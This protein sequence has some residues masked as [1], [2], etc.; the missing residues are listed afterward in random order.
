MT[1]GVSSSTE[2]RPPSPAGPDDLTGADLSGAAGTDLAGARL[3]GPAG[4]DLSGSDLAGADLQRRRFFRDFASDALQAATTLAGAAGML[5][6]EAA[7]ARDDLLER[8]GIGRER[9]TA[10]RSV[11]GEGRAGRA[12]TDDRWGGA[13][14]AVNDAVG[15]FRSPY[16]WDDGR[17]LLI[18]Q[19]RLP[20]ELVEV[21]CLSGAEVAA[22]IRDMV[23]RGAPSIGQAAAYGLALTAAQTRSAGA[24]Q[25]DA[26]LRGTAQLLQAARP[27]AVNLGWAM[28]R[29]LARYEA[30]G[31]PR[32]SGEAVADALLSEADVIAT[33]AMLEHATLARH[34]AALFP[35]DGKSE[36]RI[37]THCNT[38][39]LAAGQVG[40]ALGV[41]QRLHAD[42]RDVHVWVDESR[43]Y[44][45]GARLTAWELARAGIPHAVIVDGAAG[46]LMAQGKVDAVVVGADRVAANGDTANKIGTYPLAVLAA[47][48]GI[49][50]YVCA[51]TSSI[52]LA[53]ADGT[54]IPLEDRPADEVTTLRGIRVAPL[55]SPALNPAFDVTP[56]EL[57]TAIVTQKGTVRAPYDVGLAEVVG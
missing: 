8:G 25:R 24:S 43:P 29:M 14:V 55:E 26:T 11:A 35:A 17:L 28:D 32:A 54:G 45:Q 16:R 33:E 48:H 15:T 51:P 3:T 42:G 37:L 49:P 57:I 21:A 22:A 6:R 18:D 1:S 31:G 36:L 5:Q 19:R 30:I 56:A 44:L 52:D 9:Q 4:T 12:F 7:A 38:G 47:R 2:R 46:S 53:T 40:T 34:G 20:D 41:I 23:I 27:T 13:V 39:P 10:S 50:F